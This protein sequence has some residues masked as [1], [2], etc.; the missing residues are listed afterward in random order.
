MFCLIFYF[1]QKKGVALFFDLK[2]QIL[3]YVIRN[4]KGSTLL[5]DKNKTV[6]QH[7]N[8]CQS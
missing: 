2:S 5:F 1:I 3:N 4:S 6:L 7:N 8:N